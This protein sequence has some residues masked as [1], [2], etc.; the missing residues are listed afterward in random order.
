MAKNKSVTPSL[1]A[2]WNH[3]ITSMSD[4]QKNAFTQHIV[5]T[6]MKSS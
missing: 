6:V 1:E 5:S 3:I 2:Q 4:E